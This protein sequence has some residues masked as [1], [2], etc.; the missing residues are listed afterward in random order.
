MTVKYIVQEVT[1]CIN[2]RSE[3][4]RIVIVYN[5]R[6]IYTALDFIRCWVLCADMACRYFLHSNNLSLW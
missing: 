6:L 5:F 4:F 1:D 3:V 2:L